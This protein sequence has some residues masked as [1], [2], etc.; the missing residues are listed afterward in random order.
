MRI[1]KISWFSGQWW[2]VDGR[3]EFCDGDIGDDNHASYAIKHAQDILT[4]GNED[5][6]SWKYIKAREVAHA[7]S[8][9]ADDEKKYDF[10]HAA[11][12][13]PE[14]FLI[15]YMQQAGI[16][17][18]I[19]LLAN[20]NKSDVR[21]FAIKN[22]KWKRMTENTIETWTLT[23]EDLRNISNGIN[24]AYNNQIEEQ[25]GDPEFSIEVVSTKKMYWDIPLSIID[26]GNVASLL[27]YSSGN[28]AK[29]N[30]RTITSQVSS[31]MYKGLPS[32]EIVF[33]DSDFLTPSP[34][35][36]RTEGEFVAAFSLKG[37]DYFSPDM[38]DR[39]LYRALKSVFGKNVNCE[40][41]IWKLI[42]SPTPL[43]NQFLKQLGYD[44]F[45]SDNYLYLFDF[46]LIKFIGF[47]DFSQGTVTND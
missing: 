44:G 10:K 38:V 40:R 25:G 12:S 2:I 39:N 34:T 42:Q 26:S 36:A 16:D 41:A 28:W 4:G 21:A 24:S 29:S 30:K 17:E 27:P 11:E 7:I 43:W 15:K 20:G 18:D 45:I 6:D 9:D 19:F 8:Q 13:D 23:Q 47:Y 32:H 46:N 5:W 35:I 14:L 33:T 37:G 1:H 3:A 22:W 31:I